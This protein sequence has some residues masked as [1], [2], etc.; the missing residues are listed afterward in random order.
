MSQ[1]V[2]RESFLSGLGSELKQIRGESLPI[3]G[4]KAL[5]ENEISSLGL[6]AASDFV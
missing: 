5:F 4:T 2:L 6:F 1:R 3:S